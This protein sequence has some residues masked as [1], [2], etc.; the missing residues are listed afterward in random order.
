[1]NNF[2]SSWI[3]FESLAGSYLYGTN[4]P[5]SDIDYRGVC[6]PDYRVLND[7]FGN[8]EQQEFSSEDRVIYS[9]R[10]FFQLA[11]DCNPSIIELLFVNDLK[12]IKKWSVYWDK[13]YSNKNIFLSNKAKFTFVGYAEQQLQRIKRYKKWLDKEM[14]QPNRKDFGL[15]EMP[16]FSYEKLMSILTSPE[17]TIKEEY[18]EYAKKEMR[19]R[20]VKEE[21]DNYKNWYDTRNPK[22]FE[23]EAKFGYDTKHGMHL[24]RLLTEGLELLEQGTITLPRP[25]CK[26]LLEIRNGKYS[27]DELLNLVGNFREKI[28]A[29]KS[30]LP[31]KP[32]LETI[33]ILY[34]QLL[35]E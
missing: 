12:V 18:K 15:G 1:M 26:E 33:R 21:W 10:K 6:I 9:L 17:E 35:G 11:S 27:Y 7:P 34:Y 14:I 2:N 8:F 30:I 23:I 28:D 20:Q 13:I 19:Y 22:R 24:Y 3:I 32:N 5:E 31:A 16:L 25:D 4:T 29:C